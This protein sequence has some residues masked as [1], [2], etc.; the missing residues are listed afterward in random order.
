MRFAARSRVLQAMRSVLRLRCDK[1]AVTTAMV[2]G[3]LVA[4]R[5]DKNGNQIGKAVDLRN[6]LDL[7][8]GIPNDGIAEVLSRSEKPQRIPVD[9]SQQQWKHSS[10]A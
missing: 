1:D 4:W 9:P 8:R 3:G 6:R 7:Q 10:A 2:A 5:F